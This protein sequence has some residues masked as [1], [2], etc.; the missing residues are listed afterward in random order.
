MDELRVVVSLLP[1][2]V[3]LTDAK[4]HIRLVS[5]GFQSIFGYDCDEVVG[6]T[7]QFLYAAPE[8]FFEQGRVRFNPTYNSATLLSF[9]SFAKR[10]ARS[11]RRSFAPS[12]SAAS[13][14][15][16]W[17]IGECSRT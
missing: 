12:P 2:A 4:R 7:T 10:A 1:D 9:A 14:V 11:S 17:A 5:P 13:T 8:H 3:I 15:M 16:Y 6:Q